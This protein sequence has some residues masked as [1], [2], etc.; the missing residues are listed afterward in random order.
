VAALRCG[1]RPDPAY[2]GAAVKRRTQKHG[3]GL[4]LGAV[5]LGFCLVAAAV[6]AR[7]DDSSADAWEFSVTPYLW[8][9]T[10]DGSAGADDVD[11]PE[12]NP[13]YSFFALDNLDIAGFLSAEARKGRWSLLADTFYV[14]YSDRYPLGPLTAEAKVSGG[15]VELSTV[16]RL[17]SIEY[18]GLIAG[19]RTISLELDLALNPGPAGRQRETWV[20]PLVGLSFEFPLDGRWTLV[21]RGDIGGFGIGSE[22]DINLLFGAT[23]ALSARSSLAFSYRYLAAKFDEP[24]FRVDLAVTGY[25]LGWQFRF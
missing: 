18:I 7:A 16:Y 25:L 5:L 10:I 8:L 9:A 3:D 17:R 2:P 23:M 20:D 19:L 22:R 11:L 6:P 14:S 24:D 21:A 15:A 13:D 4:A 12:L 1:L